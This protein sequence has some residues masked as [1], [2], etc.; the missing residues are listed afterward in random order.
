MNGMLHLSDV[1]KLKILKSIRI[2]YSNSSDFEKYIDNHI[3]DISIDR[4]EILRRLDG[5]FLEDEFSLLCHLMECCSSVTPLGQN[6]ATSP[7]LKTPDFLVTFKTKNGEIPCFVEVKTTANFETKPISS[8]MLTAYK[9]FAAKFNL[10]IFFASRI[11]LGTSFLWILQSESEFIDNKR[12][13]KID[14]YT[15]TCGYALLN[16]YAFTIQSPFKLE[17]IFRADDPTQKKPKFEEFGYLTSLSILIKNHSS[18]L[19]TSP[20]LSISV[21]DL[22]PVSFAINALGKNI[23][24][25]KSGYAT[26]VIK[27]YTPPEMIWLSSLVVESNKK[28]GYSGDGTTEVNASRFLARIE[29]GLDFYIKRSHLLFIIEFFN[30][31]MRDNGLPDILGLG[32]F[33]KQGD[34][35]K[36]LKKLTKLKNI[37]NRCT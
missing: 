23:E 31:K 2:G 32:D 28:I 9:N 27:Q 17:M 37:T 12:K 25:R 19:S 5:Y 15:T 8:A 34:R 35:G 6:P 29:K 14:N 16:D 18:T 21:D 4:S 20:E 10:P 11:T 13:T 33:G 26:T 22:I 7:A 24:V 1:E 3:N 30:N 36:H